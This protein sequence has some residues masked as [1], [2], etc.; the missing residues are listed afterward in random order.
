M[1]KSFFLVPLGTMLIFITFI[2]SC[3]KDIDLE[4]KLGD[5]PQNAFVQLDWTSLEKDFFSTTRT[6][7]TSA[8]ERTQYRTIFHT[9][10]IAA[11]NQIAQENAR[12]HFVDEL[13]TSAGLPLWI[14][15]SVRKNTTTG[16]TMVVI[17]M[18]KPN[19][20]QISAFISLYK[21]QNEFDGKF[22]INGIGRGH[23]LDTLPGNI[24]NKKAFAGLTYKLEQKI[25]NST[26]PLVS[27][28]YCR[29]K[30]QISDGG[31]VGGGPGGP[32]GPG[33]ISPPTQNCEWRYIEVCNDG[34]GS[35][36][37]TGGV[38]PLHMDHD[39]DGIPNDNDQDWLDLV[40]KGLTQNQF[41]YHVNQYWEEYMFDDYGDYDTFYG[42][43][44]LNGGTDIDFFLQ[45][46][47]GLMADIFEIIRDAMDDEFDWQEFWD[48]LGG[49]VRCPDMDMTGGAN[50]REINCDWFYAY[51]CDT[52]GVLWWDDIIEMT[53][54]EPDP[55][56]Q[57]TEQARFCEHWEN[58]Y[59]DFFTSCDEMYSVLGSHTN[60]WTTYNCD[61]YSPYYESCVDDFARDWFNEVI[62]EEQQQPTG[63]VPVGP[64]QRTMCANF[65]TFVTRGQTQ[66][67]GVR[68]LT[69][70]LTTD[71]L[72]TTSNFVLPYVY[73]RVDNWSSCPGATF[74]TPAQMAAA[75]I[76]QAVTNTN[77]LVSVG[78]GSAPGPFLPDFPTQADINMATAKA[79]FL[80][81]LESAFRGMVGACTPA[82][83]APP[84]SD[85][86]FPN[87]LTAEE[88]QVNFGTNFVNYNRFSQFCQ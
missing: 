62:Y 66:T 11:Y 39:Q 79:T 56:Y 5:S 75:A 65:F 59:A 38:I 23:L 78:L 57:G 28:A 41:N 26:D 67:G 9:E 50:D 48:D 31:G 24:Y 54:Y 55:N 46:L 43:I 22:V 37:I 47:G 58:N 80:I 36:W 14:Q 21:K 19:T 64:G 82:Q 74:T 34:N 51:V 25:F 12:H 3:N 18:A 85:V 71:Q 13:A 27:D 87:L 40:A 81:Q 33:L 84:F 76:N 63:Q 73:F 86:T 35:D 69:I 2:L 32:G 44:D 4:K 49:G 45:D 77:A 29:L 42:N 6:Q 60:N 1:K 30:R 16:E 20:N 68:S 17:P 52:D 53:P 7:S 83:S 8:I 15:S 88:H 72:G 70:S 10:V 61:F